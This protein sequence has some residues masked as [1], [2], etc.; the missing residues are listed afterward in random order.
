M[1]YMRNSHFD[2][3]LSVNGT[4]HGSWQ[5]HEGGKVSAEATITKPGG[6]RPGVAVPATSPSVEM[7]TLTRQFTHADANTEYARLKAYVGTGAQAVV[8]M[9]ALDYSGLAFGTPQV[10]TGVVQGVTPPQYDAESDDIATLVVE[11]MPN[12]V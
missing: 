8:S 9:Q 3:T 7:V 11:I 6:M 4:P 1:N 2:A 5:K 12:G 10:N